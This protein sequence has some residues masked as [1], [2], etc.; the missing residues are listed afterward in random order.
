MSKNNNQ[1]E[2]YSLGVSII[3]IAALALLDTVGCVVLLVGSIIFIAKGH[4]GLAVALAITNIII[5]DA[6]PFVDEIFQVIVV[7]IPICKGYA[8]GDSAEQITKNVIDSQREYNSQK[9][10]ALN[11]S[12]KVTKVINSQYNYNNY[13]SS[14]DNEEYIDTYYDN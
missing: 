3:I 2:P 14:E 5:P 11:E 12:Q 7:A 9:T 8:N 4:K 10:N 1:V 13:D 6:L